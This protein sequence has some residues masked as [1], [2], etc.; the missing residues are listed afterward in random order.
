MVVW[1][2]AGFHPHHSEHP[3][4]PKGVYLVT[5][6]PYS[7]D[8]NPIEKLW[9]L[10]QEQTANHLRECWEDAE[11][12]LCFVGHGWQHLQANDSAK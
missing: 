10:L 5:L 4:V 7:P 9:D 6:P 1:D 2:G 3:N 11:K 8:L 12:V